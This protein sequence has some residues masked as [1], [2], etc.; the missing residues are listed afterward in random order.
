MKNQE[1]KNKCI[2]AS[3]TGLG[4]AMALA[5]MPVIFTIGVVG[6]ATTKTLETGEKVYRA[7][8]RII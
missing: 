8:R 3:L 2:S 7:A 4:G 5:A 1:I 6:L